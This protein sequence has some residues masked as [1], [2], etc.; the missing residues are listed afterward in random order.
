MPG[1]RPLVTPRVPS[2][3]PPGVVPGLVG[4]RRTANAGGVSGLPAVMPPG[5]TSRVVTKICDVGRDVLKS[6]DQLRALVGM[7]HQRPERRRARRQ[8]DAHAVERLFRL[9]DRSRNGVLVDPRFE[10]AGEA[11]GELND[12]I[13]DSAGR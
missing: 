13:D 7:A 10:R 8:R 9:V 6:R 3:T 5:G 4:L 11:F 1:V 12:D 2:G